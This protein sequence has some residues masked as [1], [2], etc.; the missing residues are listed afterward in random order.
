MRIV[1]VLILVA[2][3]PRPAPPPTTASSESLEPSEPV[4]QARAPRLIPRPE[5]R[6]HFDDV[7]FEGSFAAWTVGAEQG[8]CVG[9]CETRLPPASTFKVPHA[10]IALDLGVLEGPEELKRWDGTEREFEVWNADHTLASAIR[11]SVVWYFQAVARD[12]GVT[13]ME[14]ALERID[15]GNARVGEPIDMIWLNGTLRISPSEQVAW[16]HRLH[17]GAFGIDRGHVDEVLSMTELA[18]AGDVV[19]RGKSGWY[20]EA[21]ETDRGW[22]VGCVDGPERTCF[23]TV[24]AADEPFDQAAFRQAR[25]DLSRALLGEMGV[26]VPR[27]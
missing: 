10:L 6:T 2:C 4:P 22:L 20:R 12:I 21:G 18:R 26:E 7:G 15:Y 9:D 5:W 3:V 27:G 13:R 1:P 24:I 14:A 11:D 19:L 16:W 8:V 23:A 17:E 25:H